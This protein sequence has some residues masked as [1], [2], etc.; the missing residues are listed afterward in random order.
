MKTLLCLAIGVSMS[1]QAT[2]QEAIP[3][4]PQRIA[5]GG[6]AG[7]T[8]TDT[9]AGYTARIH[10]PPGMLGRLP[11]IV[12]LHGA[13]DTGA[14]VQRQSQMDR[15]SDAEGFMTVYPTGP[16]SGW[17]LNRGAAKSLKRIASAIDCADNSRVYLTGFSRGAA[18]TFNVACT[19][20]P[21]FAAY[22]GVAFP[23]YRPRCE[24]A[25]PAP[26]V[27]LH[28]TKDDSVSFSDGHERPNGSPTPPALLAMRR[29]ATHNGCRK[30]PTATTIGSDVVLR[31]WARCQQEATI[32]FYTIKGGGHQWPFRAIPAAPLLEP[33]QSWAAVGADEVMWTFF[34][35]RS[36][37]PTHLPSNP[38]S[39]RVTP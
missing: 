27:Y 20:H 23:D 25:P 39:A 15:L 26:I 38:G 1:C 22:G 7:G 24:D 2:P 3:S 10:R 13:G 9:L 29:W 34:K 12:V 36:L 19:P 17:R 5:S 8:F 21:V 32:E 35:S 37:S 4:T 11:T 16:A 18:M 33:G 6:C 30:M 14:F 31:K 28:G